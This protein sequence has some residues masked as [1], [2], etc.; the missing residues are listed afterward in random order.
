MGRAKWI[1]GPFLSLLSPPQQ[2]FCPSMEFSATAKGSESVKILKAPI[3]MQ[4]D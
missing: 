2:Q 1:D 3:G 4:Y